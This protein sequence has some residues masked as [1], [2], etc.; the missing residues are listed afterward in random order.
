MRSEVH[1]PVILPFQLEIVEG[2]NN[3]LNSQKMHIE[4]LQ[5]TV[6]SRFTIDLYKMDLDRVLFMLKKYFRTRAVK[7]EDQLDAIMS[8]VELQDCLSFKEKTF[9]SKLHQLNKSYFEQVLYNRLESVVREDFERADGIYYFSLSFQLLI[10][11][12]ILPN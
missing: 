8:D 1:A 7:I 12:S 5:A 10:S 3:L 11:L 2:I 6:A 9:A 4:G